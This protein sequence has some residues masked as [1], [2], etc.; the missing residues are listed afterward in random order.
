[1]RIKVR[2]LGALV[3]GALVLTAGG[4]FAAEADE[5]AAGAAQTHW[6]ACHADIDIANRDALQRGARNFTNYCLGCHSLKYE[7]YSR[8]GQDL[9]IPPDLLNKYLV[10]PGDKDTNYI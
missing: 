1:M 6:K 3:C 5:G 10:Q 9:A 7:R 2:A 8:L 4:V